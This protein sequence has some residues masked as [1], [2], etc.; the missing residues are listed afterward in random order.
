MVLFRAV[1]LSPGGQEPAVLF[2][3][4][5]HGPWRDLAVPAQLGMYEGAA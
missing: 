1:E 5:S 3:P 2:P 4:R